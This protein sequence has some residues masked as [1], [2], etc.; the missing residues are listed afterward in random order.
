V[1]FGHSAAGAAGTLAMKHIV[2]M[3]DLKAADIRPPAL[4]SR[5]RQVSIAESEV[6]FDRSRLIDVDCPACQSPD[7]SAAFAQH[8]FSYVECASCR[9]VYV[10]PRP[11]EQD[12][13]NYYDNSQAGKYRDFMSHETADARRLHVLR[14][15][16]AWVGRIFDETG[17][18]AARTYADIGTAHPFVLDEVRRLA[19]FEDLYSVDPSFAVDEDSDAKDIEPQDATLESLGA[20]TAFEQLEHQFCPRDFLRSVHDM[21]IDGGIFFL[22]TRTIS[23]FDLQVLWDRAPYIFVPEHL[24]LLSIE[25]IRSLLEGAGFRLLEL[26]TPG[27]LDVEFVQRAIAEDPTIELPRFVRYLLDGRGAETHSDFQSFLQKNRLS[28]HVRIAAQ[29]G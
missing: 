19:L 25:G 15:R 2:V 22:T 11:S 18:A 6:F 9:S 13:T 24:N 10:S 28:S 4:L 21:L 7:K 12:L 23:G 20:V 29:K 17:N 1:R 5:F 8:G 14:S 3:S 26:S 16:I 27:Q